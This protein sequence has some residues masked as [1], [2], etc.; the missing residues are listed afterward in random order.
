MFR[1][2]QDNQNT[3]TQ[4]FQPFLF[5]S[6]AIA[7][8][9]MFI[10]G[11]CIVT[12]PQHRIIHTFNHLKLQ[13]SRISLQDAQKPPWKTFT[14]KT[15]DNLQKIFTRA[16]IDQDTYYSIIKLKDAKSFLVNLRPKQIFYFLFDKQH[17]LSKL[18]FRLDKLKYLELTHNNDKW[19]T[20][21][22][23]LELEKK[24]K[25]IDG[26]IQQSFEQSTKQYHVPKQITANLVNIFDSRVDFAK[27]IR[28][29]D[30]FKIIYEQ[31][32]SD[33]KP[34]KSGNIIAAELINRNKTY[35]AIRYQ[36]EHRSTGYYMPNGRNWHL[37]FMRA[38][39]HYKRISSA[40]GARRMHPILHI[41]RRHEG[42][43]LTASFGTPI[44]ASGDGRIVYRGRKGGY[45]KA[46]IIHHNRKYTTLYAHMSRF[47]PKLHVGSFVREGE[48]IGYVGMTGLATGPH[49]HYE[50]HIYGIPHDPMKVK[51]PQ[52]S[53]IPRKERKVY[54]V[55]AKKMMKQLNNFKS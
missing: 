9:L 15:E 49:V 2:E 17:N 13:V 22:I 14:V 28:P 6:C 47:A 3:K 33:K 5:I 31:Y 26:F 55:Y 46:I 32:Y 45:G 21:L 20:D 44:R 11:I 12:K 23:T 30:E 40:F 24:L 48:V 50:F 37:A 7:I 54:L 16:G 43:D 39:L 52:A 4:K 19:S 8:M 36:P 29:H 34:I 53:P 10:T 42:V 25:T 41:V 18:I 38:P 51:L 1:N 27:Q 35:Y